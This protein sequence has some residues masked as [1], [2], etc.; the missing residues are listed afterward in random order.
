[1]NGL[2]R[3]SRVARVPCLALLVSAVLACPAIDWVVTSVTPS[4]FRRHGERGASDADLRV[5]HQASARP[6][7]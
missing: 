6:V 1:M 5:E 7:G 2:E 3:S 4:Q